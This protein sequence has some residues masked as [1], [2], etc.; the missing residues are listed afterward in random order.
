MGF[1]LP[2]CGR[3][4]FT[5]PDEALRRLF[6]YDGPALDIAPR[7]NI[8][9][10]Q[11]CTAIRLAPAGKRAIAQLRWGLLPSWAKDRKIAAS[12]INARAESL[13]EKPAFRAAFA[14]RRCL[15]P[16]D[17]FF[18]WTGEGK[19]KRPY[20]IVLAGGAPFAFAGLWERWRDPAAPADAA[21]VDSFTIVTTDAAPSIAAIH[22][23]MPAI[24]PPEHFARWLDAE[25]NPPPAVQA[26]LARY[27]GDDFVAHAVADR[28][29]NARNDDA[30]CLERA[31]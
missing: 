10:T 6:G 12:L 4:S 18:V 14:K 23:R 3:F 1:A 26:L 24:L 8:A 28:V 29:N 9:P 21:P 20:R 17:G 11:L 25:N 31:G 22:H 15:I 7:Y 30:A 27:A 13:A 16:A 5:N 2:M 19:A